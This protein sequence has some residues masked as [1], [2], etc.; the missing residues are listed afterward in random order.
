MYAKEAHR[1]RTRLFQEKFMYSVEQHTEKYNE[2]GDVIRK[3]TYGLR[4]L[5]IRRSIATEIWS[6]DTIQWDLE[7]FYLS[8]WNV[9]Q[10]YL[11]STL[12]V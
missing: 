2:T 12:Q 7:G 6:F 4:N 10:C 5:Q 8:P 11:E 9:L 3:L 1:L